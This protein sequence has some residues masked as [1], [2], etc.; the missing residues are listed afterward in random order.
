MRIYQL[1]DCHLHLGD[2]ASRAN[3]IRALT[4]IEEAD[5][6]DVLLLTGDLICGPCVEIYTQFKAIVQAHTSI[7]KIFAIAGNH[8]DL[9]MMKSVFSDSR[10]QVKDHVH[11]ND[12][13]SLCFVDSS[14]KPLSNM[15]LG[16]GRVSTKALSALKKFTRKHRSIV[17]IHHPVVNLGAKWFT[18]I[19]IENNLAVMEAIHP[20]T[21]AILSGHAHAFFKEP[22]KIQERII[23]L[24]VSPATS[25]G[26]EHTNPSYEK[27]TNIGIMAFDLVPTL[28]LTPAPAP[29]P[30]VGEEIKPEKATGTNNR[31]IEYSLR[32]SVIN[33]NH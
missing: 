17:V 33:L 15:S 7:V 23:P 22:I 5:D 11:L 26:F 1:S 21:L 18:E 12:N 2:E 14:Q 30:A 28:A 20:Q 31:E 9:A 3:L 10:I 16:G 19:G 8:D 27:N 25:Y 32:E 4:T 13:L 24:I 6:G 29:A